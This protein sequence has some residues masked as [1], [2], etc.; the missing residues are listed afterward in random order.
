MGRLDELKRTGALDNLLR[1]G[2][3]YS[4]KLALLDGYER[5]ATPPAGGHKD[6]YPSGSRSSLGSNRHALGT[7][8]PSWRTT[9]PVLRGAALFSSPSSTASRKPVPTGRPRNGRRSTASKACGRSSVTNFTVRWLGEELPEK[10]QAF[11]TPFSPR[12]T[13]DLGEEKLVENT[14]DL[15]ADVTVAFFD[16]TSIY[17][18]GEGLRRAG[19]HQRSPSRSQADGGRARP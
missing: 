12:C 1:S 9:V 19:H 2:I 15:F 18:E 7:F 17:G 3:K 5:G 6:R 4:E 8:R 16:T 13:K 10:D 14:R 11:A